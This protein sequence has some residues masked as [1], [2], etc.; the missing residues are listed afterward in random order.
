MVL[1]KIDK[2]KKSDYY[3]IEVFFSWLCYQCD[4]GR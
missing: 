3:K 4:I 1:K 2:R